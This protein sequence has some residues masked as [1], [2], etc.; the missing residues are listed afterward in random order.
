VRGRDAGFGGPC[1]KPMERSL[2]SPVLIVSLRTRQQSKP[3]AILNF[4]IS[5]SIGILA[6]TNC[7][8]LRSFKR[9]I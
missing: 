7:I 2:I 3:F 5:N 4:L 9:G 8:I 1:R 6:K